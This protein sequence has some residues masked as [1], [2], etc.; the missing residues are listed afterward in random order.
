MRNY[1]SD[2][3]HARIAQALN[4]KEEETKQFSMQS[5]RDLVRPI[6][7]KLAQEISQAIQSKD[8]YF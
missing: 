7:P 3:L 5:L 2:N 1:S 4:W 8:Y 6:S